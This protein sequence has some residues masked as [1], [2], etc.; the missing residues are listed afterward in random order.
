MNLI[1]KATSNLPPIFISNGNTGTFVDQAEDYYN[2]LKAL[3]VKTYIYQTSKKE[4]K[5]MDIWQI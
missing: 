1:F 2:V 4:L 3:G 5:G